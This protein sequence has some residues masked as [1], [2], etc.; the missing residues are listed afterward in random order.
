MFTTE[1]YHRM[2]NQSKICN[3]KSDSSVGVYQ[4]WQIYGS[5]THLPTFPYAQTYH[6]THTVHNPF[7]I[8]IFKISKHPMFM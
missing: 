8:L 4:I 2:L 5:R 7:K 1:R 3:G 6:S